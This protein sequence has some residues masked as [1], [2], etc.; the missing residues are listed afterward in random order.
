[1]HLKS[2]QKLIGKIQ[3]VGSDGLRLVPEDSR[4]RLK[5]S[6]LAKPADKAQVGQVVQVSTRSGQV[7]TG[8][9][10]Q[11]DER[12]IS[13]D[14][15]AVQIGRTEIRRVTWRSRGRGAL[16]GLAIGVGGAA[17]LVGLDSG[18]GG[19]ASAQEAA[20]WGSFFGLIGAA[21]GGAIGKERTIY[22]SASPNQTGR[23]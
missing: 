6:E 17:I 2:G 23:P 4:V 13:L 7:L 18:P 19:E 8:T 16:I 14:K 20:E 3:Q 15:D 1:V 12:F 9:L 21:V 10:R 22:D 11:A 5:V